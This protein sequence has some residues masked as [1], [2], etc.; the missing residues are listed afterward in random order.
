M[1]CWNAPPGP[2]QARDSGNSELVD[3]TDI[4]SPTVSRRNWARRRGAAIQA[5]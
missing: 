5:Q 4:L 2:G 1:I 3:R